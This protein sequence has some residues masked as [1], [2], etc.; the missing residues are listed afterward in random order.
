VAHIIRPK[1]PR[2][3][4]DPYIEPIFGSRGPCALCSTYANLTE[5]HIPPEAV[6][7]DG[8]WVAHSYLT[9]A[10][11]DKQLI[12]G[13]EF[14]GGIRF[15]TLC[16]ECNNR[17]GAREDKALVDF[18]ERVVKLVNSPLI[19]NGIMRVSGTVLSM[20]KQSREFDLSAIKPEML[21][22]SL[23]TY[24]SKNPQSEFFEAVDQLLFSLPTIP[25]KPD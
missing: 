9:S 24:C 20:E 10:A 23:R 13:R 17:L 6:G 25:T 16:A 14:R 7:N 11:A 19:L 2:R 8:S 15:R 1:R 22:N 3:Y 4:P 18:F 12:F 5:D 21:K